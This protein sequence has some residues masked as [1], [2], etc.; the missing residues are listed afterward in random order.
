[1]R[2]WNRHPNT[3][4]VQ[5]HT[6]SEAQRP[7]SIQGGRGTVASLIQHLLKISKRE[8]NGGFKTGMSGLPD[9]SGPLVWLLSNDLLV[10][11]FLGN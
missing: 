7:G 8:K 5:L 2:R 10:P 11:Q 3:F 9:K 4:T 6:E 1:M